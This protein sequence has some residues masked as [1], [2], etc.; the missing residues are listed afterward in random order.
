MPPS[1]KQFSNERLQLAEKNALRVSRNQVPLQDL[2]EVT[3]YWPNVSNDLYESSCEFLDK[4]GSAKNTKAQSWIKDPTVD[5][6]VLP[7]IWRVVRNSHSKERIG[8]KGVIQMLRRGWAQK[9]DWAEGFV[10]Q[11]DDVAGDSATKD[12]GIAEKHLEIHFRNFDP[13]KSKAAVEALITAESIANP[14]IN[15]VAESGTWYYL[16]VKAE[17]QED[18]CET[19]RV[20]IAQSRAYL[21]LFDDANMPTASVID[22]LY[23]LPRSIAQSIVDVYS[24]QTGVSA[25][26]D[27]DKARGVYDVT[28]R[29][30]AT[31]DFNFSNIQTEDACQRE[32]FHDYYYR[33]TE[34]D[35]N[36]FDIGD[37]PQG[38]IYRTSGP[39]PMGGFFSIVVEKIHSIAKEVDSD[40]V[41]STAETETGFTVEQTAGHKDTRVIQR[42][43][44]AVA[45]APAVATN[46]QVRVTPQLNDDCLFDNTIDWRTLNPQTIDSHTVEQTAKHTTA[47]TRYKKAASL[48]ALPTWQQGK[49]ITRQ[50]DINDTNSYDG[51]VGEVTAIA[52]GVDI[53]V[54]GRDGYNTY[55]IIRWNQ[56]A[57][58][59]PEKDADQ[60]L[61]LRAFSDNADGTVNYWFVKR[62]SP[63]NEDGSYTRTIP[64]TQ[65]RMKFEYGYGYRAYT[66]YFDETITKS[67]HTTAQAAYD[68]IDGA[69]IGSRI[70]RGSGTHRFIAH[71]VT[72]SEREVRAPDEDRPTVITF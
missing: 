33:L 39:R 22:K 72:I 14:V 45:K 24:V 66:V 60:E 55:H 3:R 46:K 40:D 47:R 29:R 19:I 71:K 21:Q 25:S 32:I 34:A 57:V 20:N 1:I 64:L 15:N 36:A 52:G 61:D 7:G 31:A 54:P 27:Y 6:D 59:V 35:V 8:T 56:S 11:R 50:F 49:T 44:T 65:K 62:Q 38:W 5:G 53:T 63:P 12:D 69:E 37:A 58:A 28:I 48:P 42:N 30:Y 67:T 4:Y 68:E 17:K 16:H 51:T 70:Y 41:E 18:G 10:I 43:Q 23:G 2:D 9:V 13:Q 26:A